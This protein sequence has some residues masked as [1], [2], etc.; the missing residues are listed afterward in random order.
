MQ[1]Q[2]PN[3]PI[4][5]S[6]KSPNHPIT[7]PMDK[8]TVACIQQKMHLPQDL[9][10][11]R[12]DLERFA[13]VAQA[14]N[15]RLVIFP[16]L[17][18]MMV[19]PPLLV[20]GKANLLK[21]AALGQRRSASLWQKLSGN[22]SGAMARW[23]KADLRTLVSG[24]L[25]TTPEAAWTAYTETFG[26]LAKQFGLTVVA[27]SAYL[28]DPADGMIRN[29]AG[30]FG[31]SGELLG[32][33]AKV[34]L[35]RE[36]VGIAEPGATWDLIS[37]EVGRIGL[38]LGGDVLY[39]EVGRLLAY[40]GAEILIA[41]G[42]APDVILYNKLRSAMLARMQDNQL[43]GAISFVVG[44]NEFGQQPADGSE[45]T[46]YV[47]KSAIFAPQELTPR[48]SGVL[49]EMGNHRSEGVLAAEWDF[50]ALKALWESSDT[51][52]RNQLPQASQALA[53]LY[54]RLQ[55]LPRSMDEMA[56]L[57]AESNPLAALPGPAEE[58]HSLDELPV[59]ASVTARWPLDMAHAAG[60]ADD[61]GH[62]TILADVIGGED[63]AD[64]VPS[65]RDEADETDEM[66]VIP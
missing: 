31:P 49:V 32:S 58:A 45:R 21:R 14:K 61:L 4:S 64:P 16:E 55:S 1:T 34:I 65:L 47:G 41:Q 38:M 56:L 8:I 50:V 7:H 51:P 2:S 46:A 44:T 35:H 15:A 19:V 60:D 25:D 23:A 26:G 30:V 63:E 27:P 37:T 3:Y 10:E 62:E 18:G 33:Q 39:P 9:A 28:P 66:D 40:Q 24:L 17:A 43:F 36:D 52:I 11:V 59:L 54:Q 5:Q 29:L 6:P 42:A 53:Q 57:P 12:A 22:L 20:G 48:Y 13:R